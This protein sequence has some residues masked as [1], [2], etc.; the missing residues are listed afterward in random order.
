MKFLTLVFFTLSLISSYA[1]ATPSNKTRFIPLLKTKLG[2]YEVTSSNSALCTNSRLEFND[3]NDP[4]KGFRLGEQI[5][6][7]SLHNG[8]R[9]IK[10]PNFCF[11]TSSLKYK[12]VGL[13]NSLRMSRCD[14]P[15]HERT[16]EQTITF[17]TDTTLQ[18]TLD[19]PS[20]E[21][22]FIKVAD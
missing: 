21:C 22:E 17:L 19:D 1:F 8:T 14:N 5:L 9:T 16:I 20:V 12:T 18:Y 11:I 15:I 6:F 13:E 4:E 7:N 2:N 3:P 10:K